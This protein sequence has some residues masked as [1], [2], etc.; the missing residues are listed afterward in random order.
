MA[1]QKELGDIPPFSLCEFAKAFRSLMVM[2]GN[3]LE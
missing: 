2:I 1:D 3:A